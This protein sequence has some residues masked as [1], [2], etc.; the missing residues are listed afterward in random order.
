MGFEKRDERVQ[1]PVGLGTHRP[2]Q[3]VLV[4]GERRFQQVDGLFAPGIALERSGHGV[5]DVQPIECARRLTP[6]KHLQLAELFGG[7]LFMR[8]PAEVGQEIGVD[9]LKDVLAVD[10]IGTSKGRG[11]AGVMKRHNYRGQRAS[12]GVKK[13][14]RHL[15]GTGCSADPSRLPK[16]KKMAGHYGAARATVRNLRVVKIDWENHLLLVRG[17]VPG[18]NGG[19]LVIRPTNKVPVPMPPQD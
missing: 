13:C 19:Y 14:H 9:A 10:V 11:T 5:S 12:H 17:A 8:D 7:Q 4:F 3:C 6:V 1:R 18:P 16:G 15:G 2:V